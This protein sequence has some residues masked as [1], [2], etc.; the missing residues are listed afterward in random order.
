[1]I[2]AEM[3]SEFH[4]TLGYLFNAQWDQYVAIRE[5]IV[6]KREIA[7]DLIKFALAKPEYPESHWRE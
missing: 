3:L 5:N 4:T 2:F 7:R 1:M 6:S